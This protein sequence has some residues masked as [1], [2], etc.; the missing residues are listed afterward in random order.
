M[1]GY[2]FIGKGTEYN[3]LY[4]GN[5]YQILQHLQGSAVPVYLGDIYLRDN[6]YFLDPFRVIIHMSLMA[7]AG[8]DS[9]VNDTRLLSAEIQRT[10]TEVQEAG[11]EHLGC[12]LREFVME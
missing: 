10:Q 1:Y 9:K 4:E 8:E 5:I 3:S 12:A 11:I 7:W 6:V 2:T